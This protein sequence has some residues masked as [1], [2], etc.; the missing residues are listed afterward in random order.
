MAKSSS[1][2]KELSVE[3]K[4]LGPN[5]DLHT[6]A[7]SRGYDSDTVAQESI[8]LWKRYCK[9]KAAD[10]IITDAENRRIQRLATVLEIPDGISNATQQQIVDESVK[11]SLGQIETE[12]YE[13]VEMND[14][15]ANGIAI[16]LGAPTGSNTEASGTDGSAA[17]AAEEDPQDYH[18]EAFKQSNDFNWEFA[19]Q[20]LASSFSVRLC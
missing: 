18:D 8:T 2:Q 12:D 5:F 7:Q 6:F 19:L 13:L 15:E 20:F 14:D 4:R 17:S 10:G 1:C 16:C 3:V 9:R 11:R